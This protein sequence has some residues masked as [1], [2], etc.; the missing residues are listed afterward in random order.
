[1]ITYVGIAQNYIEEAG[2]GTPIYTRCC[3]AHCGD[4]PCCATTIAL[5]YMLQTYF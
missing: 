2:P 3:R 4:V 1:M 5:V